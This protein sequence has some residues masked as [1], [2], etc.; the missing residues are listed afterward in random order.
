M[1]TFA[2]LHDDNELFRGKIFVL[3]L[4][5]VTRESMQCSVL[6]PAR[7]CNARAGLHS[8]LL[9]WWWWMLYSIARGITL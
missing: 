3:L 9:L 6:L 4:G 5:L 8:A 7:A 2:V 1:A